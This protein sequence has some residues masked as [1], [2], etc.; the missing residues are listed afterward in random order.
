M[1]WGRSHDRAPADPTSLQPRRELEDSRLIADWIRTACR[2]EVLAPKPGNVYPGA[3]FDDLAVDDF[4]RSA[5]LIAPILAET[6]SRGVGAAIL[7][8]VESTQSALGRNTNLGIILLLAPLAA[9]P[10]DRPLSAG[11]ADVLSRTDV[12]DARLLYRAIRRAQP[13]GMGHSAEQDLSDEPTLPLVGI[14]RLA[15]HRDRIAAQYANGFR[16]V[17]EF[18]VPELLAWVSRCESTSEAIVGLHLSLLAQ[19]PDTLIARKCGAEVAQESARRAAAVL[20]AGWPY[21]DGG[22]AACDHLNQ[23][24]RADGHRRNPGTTADLIA[25]TLFAAQRDHGW[26]AADAQKGITEGHKGREEE[27]VE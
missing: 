3:E 24:L 9:V 16:D 21:P 27:A 18:A 15:E 12:K 17:L 8:A 7:D 2:L 22:R 23:W 11:I 10:L 26:T 19:R 5:D 20:D 13:G 4:L 6:R 14:M 1:G 25:A